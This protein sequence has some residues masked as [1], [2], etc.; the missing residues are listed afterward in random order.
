MIQSIINRIILIKGWLH[1]ISTF[2][3][4]LPSTNESDEKENENNEKN[5]YTFAHT[6]LSYVLFNVLFDLIKVNFNKK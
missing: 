1:C 4:D 3:I 5:D 2:D 6:L